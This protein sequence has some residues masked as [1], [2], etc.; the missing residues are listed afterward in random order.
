MVAL[1]FLKIH[2]FS[3]CISLFVM[4]LVQSGKFQTGEHGCEV[5]RQIGFECHAFAGADRSRILMAIRL[6]VKWTSYGNGSRLA[7]GD[8]N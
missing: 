1:D 7:R 2:T 5:V 6:A 4:S 8:G 3:D